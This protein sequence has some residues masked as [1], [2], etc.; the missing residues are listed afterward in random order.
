MQFMKTLKIVFYLLTQLPMALDV[1]EKFIAIFNGM[2]KDSRNV[3]GDEIL[4]HMANDDSG[5]VTDIVKKTCEGVGC[6]S[7]VKSPY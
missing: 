3:L 1:I 4:G 7:D 2:P 5:A 6:G